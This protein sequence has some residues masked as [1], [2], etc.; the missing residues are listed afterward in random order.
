MT[1]TKIWKEEYVSRIDEDHNSGCIVIFA[2]LTKV[3]A[4]Y[5]IESDN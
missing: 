2:I 5:P 4:L 3:V 1:I